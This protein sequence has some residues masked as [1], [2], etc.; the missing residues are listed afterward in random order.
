MIP[1]WCEMNMSDPFNHLGSIWYHSEPEEAKELKFFKISILWH[2][3][4]A[5][6]YFGDYEISKRIFELTIVEFSRIIWNMIGIGVGAVPEGAKMKSHIIRTL[7][8][9]L[10][11]NHFRFMSFSN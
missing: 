3:D 7:I 1:K 4:L 2:S 9:Y 8:R 6:A 5:L 11:V 10:Q